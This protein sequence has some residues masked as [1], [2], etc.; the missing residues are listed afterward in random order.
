[1]HILFT[2]IGNGIDLY[3]SFFDTENTKWLYV[4][5]Q[6]YLTFAI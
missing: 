2:K 5:T 1:M 3:V 4:S 6:Y